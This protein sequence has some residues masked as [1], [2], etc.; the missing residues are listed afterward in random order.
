M[1]S[2]SNVWGQ[3]KPGQFNVIDRIN[4]LLQVMWVRAAM[5]LTRPG[6]ILM[7]LLS[8]GAAQICLVHFLI[9]SRCRFLWFWEV[10]PG[11]SRTIGLVDCRRRL[12]QLLWMSSYGSSCRMAR[13]LRAIQMGCRLSHPPKRTSPRHMRGD[14][15]VGH[16]WWIAW[17]CSGAGI[18]VSQEN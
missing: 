7:L 3:D 16:S 4:L 18:A 8:S 13:F 9:C 11:L 15:R 6:F 1:L 17:T 2:R 5:C 10:F 12:T 14:R